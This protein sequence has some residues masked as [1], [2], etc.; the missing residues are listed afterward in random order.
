MSQ[1]HRMPAADVAWLHM[2][3]PTNLMINNVVMCF[4]TPV[5]WEHVKEICRERLV[6]RFPRFSQRVAEPRVPLR[7][8]A[9]ED[10]PHFD[11]EHHFHRLALPAPGDHAALLELVAD[12]M[13]TPLDHDK[14]LWDMYLVEGYGA[15]CAIVSR[16]HHSIADGIALARALVSLTDDA[17][18]GAVAPA[19]PAER[20]GTRPM[21]AVT[22][23]LAAVE[24]GVG[25]PAAE[26][27]GRDGHNVAALSRQLS[28]LALTAK[29]RTPTLTKLL[30]AGSDA[31]SVLKGELG[32]VQRVASTRPIPLADL[33]RAG[34][35]TDTTVNDVVL[36]AVTGALR[37]YLLERDSPLVEIRAF[38]PFNLRPLSEPIPSDLGNR[39]GPVLLTL[40]IGLSDPQERLAEIHRRMDEIKDS[41]EGAISFGVLRI[42]GMT[43]LSVE[44]VFL[45]LYTAKASALM[46]DVTGPPHPVYLAGT[47]VR[48]ML[49]WAPRPGNLSMS[50]T[51]FSYNGDLTMTLGVDAGLIPDPERIVGGVEDELAE[52]QR[53]A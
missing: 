15:G 28:R 7:P 18:E 3:R 42:L 37:S 40:P 25:Q 51:T 30:L 50:V 39:F 34:H 31:D 43:P 47:L 6:E 13:A 8:V 36:S 26:P 14:P 19:P 49:A 4:D 11:L 52:L 45:D 16:T 32:V 17:P 38:V 29:D 10:D 20:Q 12:M 33:K 44:R 5:D 21:H 27:A 41:P 22:A 2:E 46:S 1:R 48:R 35:G 23:P 53:L 24:P 9:W